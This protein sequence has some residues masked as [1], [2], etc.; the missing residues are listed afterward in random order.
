LKKELSDLISQRWNGLTGGKRERGDTG[1]EVWPPFQAKDN[2]Y[3]KSTKGK[4]ETRNWSTI[5]AGIIGEGPK[6]GGEKTRK[7][8]AGSEK[9][10][11]PDDN[12]G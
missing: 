3:S 6:G 10:K 1:G 9:K 4:G 5:P 11:K 12:R 2:L 7:V 8:E